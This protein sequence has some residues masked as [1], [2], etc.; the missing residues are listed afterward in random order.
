MKATAAALF[1]VL[2]I[3]SNAQDKD[4]SIRF[5]PWFGDHPFKLN[6]E[7]Q[8]SDGSPVSITRFQFYV[9]VPVVSGDGEVNLLP[10]EYHLIDAEDTNSWT[11][12]LPRAVRSGFQFGVDSLTNVSGAFGGDLDP[13]K[14]M[15]WAWNSGYINLKLEGSSP[16]TPYPSHEFELHLGGYLPP[17][18]TAQWVDLPEKGKGPVIIDVDVSRLIKAAD[19]RTRCNVMSPGERAVALANV[20]AQMFLV[21]AQR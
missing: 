8:L 19:V 21:D 10:Y 16:L 4:H 18:A 12:V 3:G 2:A 15:Y 1:F 14:G 7:Q 11:V 9:G 13:L 17:F 20:A 6:T 5:V